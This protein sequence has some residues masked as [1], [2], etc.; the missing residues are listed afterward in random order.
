M[1]SVT[2]AWEQRDKDE[3][4][5]AGTGLGRIRKQRPTRK[6]RRGRHR[7]LIIPEGV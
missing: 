2:A 5:E 3:K 7:E 6:A 1:A 4:A